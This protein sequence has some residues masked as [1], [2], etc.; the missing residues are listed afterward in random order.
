M[1]DLN[2]IRSQAAECR[3]MAQTA[4][5]ERQRQQWLLLAEAYEKLASE[6]DGRKQR[7]G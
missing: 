5:D 3:E 6:I 2:H 4:K 1:S 7:G